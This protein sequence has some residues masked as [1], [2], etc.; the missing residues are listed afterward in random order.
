M[1][2]QVCLNK[3]VNLDKSF[4]YPLRLILDSVFYKCPL[5]SSDN[6]LTLKNMRN[7]PRAKDPNVAECI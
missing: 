4:F 7:T 6:S 1:T 5:R 3:S 2:S